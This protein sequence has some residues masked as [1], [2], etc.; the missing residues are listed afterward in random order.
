MKKQAAILISLLLAVALTACSSSR[1]RSDPD[2]GGSVSDQGGSAPEGITSGGITYKGSASGETFLKGLDGKP[3]SVSDIT[4][5]TDGDY[6]PTAVLDKNSFSRAE[7]TGFAY[8]FK[9]NIIFEESEAPELFDEGLYIGKEAEPSSE[10]IKVSVG[11]TFGGLTV[12]SAR[13]VF[14]DVNSNNGE[15]YYE[16][17]EIEFDGNITLTGWLN[18]PSLDEKY[19]SLV[20]DMTFYCDNNNK[21][22]LSSIFNY[23]EKYGFYHL[24][25]EKLTLYTD[26][27]EIYL[28]KYP[29]YDIDFQGLK[30]GD[31]W[32]KAEITVTEVKMV[33]GI[34]GDM[35]HVTASLS[36]IK[37]LD[38]T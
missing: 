33:C 12:K 35:G 7:C 37:R 23:N 25:S 29:D 2:R 4:S 31:V 13:T 1:E 26:V 11:D 27:P 16:G 6:K 36:N 18:I 30:E 17:S 38:L 10:F 24:P 14:S 32:T 21:L 8:G 28:G 9:P 34:Q 5:L 3:I 19:P 22:P 15:G 20:L